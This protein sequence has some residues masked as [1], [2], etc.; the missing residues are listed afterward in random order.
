MLLSELVIKIVIAKAIVDSNSRMGI[1]ELW[2]NLLVRIL[3]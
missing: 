1:G 3:P 2:H